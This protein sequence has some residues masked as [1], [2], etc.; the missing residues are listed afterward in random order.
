MSA[1]DDARLN[2]IE[3]KID[4][5]AEAMISIA[6]AEEKISSIEEDRDI[7]WERLNRLS[8][9]MDIME[10]KL[11]DAARTVSIVHRLFWVVVTGAGAYVVPGFLQS[12]SL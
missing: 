5:L 10:S 4:K 6:R 11:N 7:Y 9:K 12:L 8:A 1:V 3:E 2:R